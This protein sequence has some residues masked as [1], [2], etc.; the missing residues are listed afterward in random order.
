MALAFMLGFVLGA[1]AGYSNGSPAKLSLASLA[2]VCVA[3]FLGIFYGFSVRWYTLAD[4]WQSSYTAGIVATLVSVA[5]T[6]IVF[7]LVSV[8][9]AMLGKALTYIPY[10]DDIVPIFFRQWIPIPLDSMILELIK[11]KSAVP[12]LVWVLVFASIFRPS[13][14]TLVLVLGFV[15]STGIARVVRAEVMRV[16]VLEYITAA[17]LAGF[18]T[19]RVVWRHV[20]PN[21][22]PNL[23]PLLAFGAADSITAEATLSFL[24]VGVPPHVATWGKLIALGRENP[25]A[26][27][28]IAF[29]AALIALVLLCLYAV[30]NRQSAT[31]DMGG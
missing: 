3:T 15:A 23:L 4:A 9:V 19:A 11:I 16:R 30:G 6:F 17:R 12:S 24:G 8:F 18:S 1:V 22:L 20:L 14:P 5:I 28:L 26:W 29:P 27:W 21:I 31:I 25:A 2:R 10:S 13:L 7:A